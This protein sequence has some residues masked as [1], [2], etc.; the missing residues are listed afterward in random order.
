M[1]KLIFGLFIS[2]ELF[3]APQHIIIPRN[4]ETNRMR[5]LYSREFPNRN[6]FEG[7][8]RFENSNGG[9]SFRRTR[10]NEIRNRCF[11]NRDRSACEYVRTY[12]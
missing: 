8:R 11:Q 12:L 9:N 5:Y 7:Y 3:A 6:T 1:K 10:E 2:L 4:R